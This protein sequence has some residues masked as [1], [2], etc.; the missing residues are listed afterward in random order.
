MIDEKKA[1]SFRGP[2]RRS[3]NV[4][5]DMHV[6]IGKT[7]KQTVSRLAKE[8]SLKKSFLMLTIQKCERNAYILK[9]KTLKFFSGVYEKETLRK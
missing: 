5:D 6:G 1:S 7:T 2:R 4:S 3:K 8:T 9:R